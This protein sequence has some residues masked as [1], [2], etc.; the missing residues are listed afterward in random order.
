MGFLSKYNKLFLWLESQ[1]FQRAQE[2]NVLFWDKYEKFL[3]RWKNVLVGRFLFEWA[4][5]FHF[6]LLPAHPWILATS[7]IHI[8]IEN[9]YMNLM[10]TWNCQSR[11]YSKGFGRAGI[12]KAITAA[13][14][15]LAK[16]DKYWNL[17]RHLY[18]TCFALKLSSKEYLQIF[19]IFPRIPFPTK[20]LTPQCEN[21]S[22]KN[23]ASK[24]L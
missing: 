13:N 22:T 21:L 15:V 8:V 11:I 6:R 2:K 7:N 12:M 10:T 4:M 5:L 18:K 9:E 24:C 20:L 23:Q 14:N 17:K 1:L 19:Y 3:F 16:C